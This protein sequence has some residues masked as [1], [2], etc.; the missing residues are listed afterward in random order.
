MEEV[1]P[2]LPRK[3]EE[4]PWKQVDIFLNSFG[5]TEVHRDTALQG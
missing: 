3:E 5:G 4:R 2:C 1:V